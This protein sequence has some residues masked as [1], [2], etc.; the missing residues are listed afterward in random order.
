MKQGTAGID[1]H[2]L[3]LCGGVGG[4]K[5]VAGLARRLDAGR[6]TVAVNTGDDFE[7]LG[8]TICPDID[9]VLYTLA[10]V[11]DPQQGW[12]RQGESWN[13][14]TTLGELGGATWF[15]LGDRD[16]AVHLLRTAALAGG[17]SLSEANAE[18]ARGL[19]VEAA[20]VP[21]SDQPVRTVLQTQA[22]EL[23][24]QDYFVRRRCAPAV[25][26]IRYRGADAARISPPLLDTLTRPDLDLIVLCPSNP[27]L[28]IDPILSVPGL[29]DH[30]TGARA[31]VIAVSPVIGGAAV[32]GPTAKI[33]RELDIPVSAASVAAHYR[34][35]LDGFVLDTGDAAE[36]AGVE[37]LGIRV[38]TAPVLM[39]CAADRTA[40]AG[41][42]VEFAARLARDA[43]GACRG[44]AP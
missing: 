43:A 8:L 19:G 32:K 16:L 25:S 27:W 15:R 17:R 39:R 34:D 40:L 44:D 41:E 4:A 13:C 42:V 29:R 7:H 37:A 2:V 10:G 22:G 18:I 6:L 5:L 3:A 23:A 30:L 24:F 33:M 31:P 28:S 38:H 35:L 14:L 12:G 26:A 20:V 9:T 11:A 21:M 1:G 36:Q